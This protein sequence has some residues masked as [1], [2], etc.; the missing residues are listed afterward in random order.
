MNDVQAEDV[1]VMVK[2]GKVLA[3]VWQG[4]GKYYLVPKLGLWLKILCQEVAEL[5]AKRQSETVEFS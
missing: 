4:P 3:V 2:D 1:K 5:E